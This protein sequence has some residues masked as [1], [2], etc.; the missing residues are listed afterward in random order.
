MQPSPD[1]LLLG[2]QESRYVDL[3]FL[4]HVVSQKQSRVQAGLII[5]HPAGPVGWSERA[6]GSDC[7]KKNT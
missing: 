7:Y 3:I 6:M 4:Q 5:L 2:Q 1:F